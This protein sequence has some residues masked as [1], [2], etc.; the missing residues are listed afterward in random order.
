MDLSNFSVLG[1]LRF[2]IFS[3]KPDFLV[4]IPQN[5]SSGVKLENRTRT[6]GIVD[7]NDIFGVPS[8][9]NHA[10][11]STGNHANQI[12]NYY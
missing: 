7:S 5:K 1:F 9:Y 4:S 6:Y 10:N 8:F 12:L 2:H 11:V 3:G